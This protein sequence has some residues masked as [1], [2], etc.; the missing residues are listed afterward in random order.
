MEIRR[1]AFR[2]FIFF[3]MYRHRYHKN[4]HPI[5]INPIF[6]NPLKNKIDHE[7]VFHSF[8]MP[9]ELCCTSS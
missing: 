7:K 5:G 9:I 2:I 6:F 8:T 4:E 3:S 1:R